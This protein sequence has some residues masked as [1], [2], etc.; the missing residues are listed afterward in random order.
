MNVIA[1]MQRGKYWQ[2]KNDKARKSQEERQALRA[3]R[4]DSRLSSRL[5]RAVCLEALLSPQCPQIAT[6]ELSARG[7]MPKRA[8]TPGT[9]QHAFFT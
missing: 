7:K 6:A 5:A 2:K 8:A 9:G 4:A 1:R 3:K